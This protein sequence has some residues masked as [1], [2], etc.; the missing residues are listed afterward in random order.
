MSIKTTGELRT[1]LTELMTEVRGGKVSVER[2]SVAIKAAA[3]VN[4][5]IYSEIK[6]KALEKSLGNAVKKMGDMEID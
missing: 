1:F 2:A 4:E 5:S 6:T 3:Q